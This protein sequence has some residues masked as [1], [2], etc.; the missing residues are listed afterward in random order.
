MPFPN[1][2]NSL[3]APGV[4]GDFASI[5]P[6]SSVLA[7]VDAFVAPVGGTP[8]GWFTFINPTTLQLSQQY[9]SGDLVGFVMR[10]QQALITQYLGEES[11]VIPEGFMVT[12]MNGGDFYAYFA[13]GATAGQTV[14]ADE[15]TGAPV[16]GSTSTSGTATAGFTGTATVVANSNVLTIVAATDGILSIG[17]VITATGVPAG[18]TVTG[19]L[20]GTGGV[21]TYTMSANATTTEA[22]AEAITTTSTVLNVT[23]V[24]AGTFSQGD[25]ISGTGVTSGT[26]ITGYGTGTGGVGTYT[27]SPAQ[28]FVP[29]TV[30]VANANVATGFTVA[31]GVVG[32]G[33]AKISRTVS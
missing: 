3:Q 23:A 18:T 2:V 33:I 24:A 8:V 25:P 21:G 9:A 11:L 20:T 12:A 10:N 32:A 7:G 5:N 17:D 14:Y 6:F 16:A 13:D 30:T 19:L 1:K 29:A 31:V 22:S 26:T 27:I 28:N 15:N 4:L